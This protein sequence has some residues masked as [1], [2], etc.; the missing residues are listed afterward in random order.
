VNAPRPLFALLAAHLQATRNRA[1]RELGRSGVWVLGIFIVL[2]G[3]T[4]LA[5]L[6]AAM[7]GLGWAFGS[8]LPGASTEALLGALLFGM[9]YLGGATSGSISGAKQLTCESYRTYPVK[10]RSIFLAELVASAADLMPIVLGVATLALCAGLAIANWRLLPLLPLVVIEGVAS[11]LVVQLLVGALAERLI[12]RLRLALNV[13]VIVLAIGIVFATMIP[14]AS[15][16]SDPMVSALASASRAREWL[17]RGAFVLPT[18]WTARS[19]GALAAGRVG[20]ALAY[21]AIPIAA[22]A[23]LARLAAHLIERE[24]SGDAPGDQ[25]SERLWSFRTAAQGV[26]RLQFATIL[27]SRVGRF[28]LVFPLMVVVLVRGPLTTLVGRAPWAV[29][30]A[31]IYVA[32]L[33]S[34]FQLNQFGLDAHG[35]KALLLLPIDEADIWRGKARGLLLYQTLQATSL[36]IFLVLVQRPS[37]VEIASGVLVFFAMVSVQNAVGRPT[38]VLMPRMMPRK[39]IQSNATPLGAVLIALGMSLGFGGILGVA[40]A[41]LAKSAPAWRPVVAAALLG[42]S[43]FAQRALLPHATHLLRR[44]KEKLIAALG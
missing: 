6:W 5:P 33:G 29:P 2:I 41:V 8:G 11:A 14:I 35:T 37:I 25:P 31:F 39:R 20:A 18:T 30:G 34:Q 4:L 10:L 15:Q 19:L 43:L 22:L 1:L 44:R 26:A 17:E 36:A 24:V 28:G 16:S 23:V 12:R 13:L 27:D 38:S 40:F 42:A 32:L 3:T 21:H 9:S 7:L